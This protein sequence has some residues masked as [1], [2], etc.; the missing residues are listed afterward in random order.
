MVRRVVAVKPIM[1]NVRQI[2]TSIRR[3]VEEPFHPKTNVEKALLGEIEVCR[4]L[5]WQCVGGQE[6]NRQDSP[7]TCTN[8][9]H[10]KG[11]PLPN[12][13]RISNSSETKQQPNCVEIE[14]QVNAM[15]V[16]EL[17]K[18]LKRRDL[19]TN[20]L[21]K[22]L[23]ARLRE[24][25][26]TEN[27][28]Q[29]AG[30]VPHH[31]DC[32]SSKQPIGAEKSEASVA[33]QGNIKGSKESCQLSDGN[34]NFTEMRKV[35]DQQK[36]GSLKSSVNSSQSSHEAKVSSDEVQGMVGSEGVEE[37]KWST[38][39]TSP[40]QTLEGEGA[41]NIKQYWKKLSKPANASTVTSPIKVAMMTHSESKKKKS[42]IRMVVKTVQKVLPAANDDP[43]Q[44]IVISDIV[45]SA[46]NSDLTDD[47]FDGPISEFSETSAPLVPVQISKA[48]SVRDLVSKIQKST[49]SAS[50]TT[51]GVE[52]SGS[53]LSKNLQAKKEARL[54]RMA[55]I[56][57]KS[58]PVMTSK[59]V[60]APK[61]YASTL[62]SL[63]AVSAP[64]GLKKNNLA[65]QMREKAATMRKENVLSGVNDVFTS[66]TES[67]KR[68]LQSSADSSDDQK[69]LV[70]SMSMQG[71]LKKQKVASPM[72]TY[73]ISDREKSDS[74][75]SDSEAG[76][77]KQKKKIP[78]WAQKANLLLALEEQYNGCVGGL[79]V[80]PDE[81]FPEVQTCDLEAIFGGKKSRYTLRTS[82]GNWTR[83]KVTTAEKLVY[84]RTMGFTL[85]V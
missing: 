73:E 48:G 1:D 38:N 8:D 6:V 21:K 81:M 4:A 12:S 61:E 42:P 66:T 3:V 71:F 34:D 45:I 17:R 20:G 67:G 79:R 14:F 33:Q 62:S 22:Q 40:K 28:T 30:S 51:G 32:T 26:A 19:E 9:K 59:H 27:T 16:A 53:A 54:A 49:S 65:A 5:I 37:E 68:D 57:G 2:Q 24:A 23:Q 84:K 10:S 69:N 31:P 46:S 64:V 18:E 75:T 29:R 41:S 58:K 60:L 55:E 43:V 74:D 56:R 85:Q 35:S 13:D 78:V 44:D 83:D 11:I 7:P 77:E 15:K 70:V 52:G 36:T 63:N 25:M 80:D 50:N 76:N 72:S 47:D 39:S 82:S